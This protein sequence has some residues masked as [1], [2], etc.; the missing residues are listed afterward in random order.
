MYNKTDEIPP[1]AVEI[2]YTTETAKSGTDEESSEKTR[3]RLP[4]P[5]EP[6][7]PGFEK[8]G[9]GFIWYINHPPSEEEVVQRMKDLPK[10]KEA[11]IAAIRKSQNRDI[12]S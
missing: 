3:P 2:A 7:P 1:D 11:I 6:R 8:P 5:N 4:K 10:R 9:S 12:S